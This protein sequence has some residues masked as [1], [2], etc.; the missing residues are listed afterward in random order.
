MRTISNKTR[1]IYVILY[2]SIEKY[3]KPL[4]IVKCNIA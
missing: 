1:N 4:H 3:A 2:E